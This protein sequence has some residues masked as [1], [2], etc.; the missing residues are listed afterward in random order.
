MGVKLKQMQNPGGTTGHG[1]VQQSDGSLATE[2]IIATSA[3]ST[4]S[5]IAKMGVEVGCVLKTNGDGA[6]ADSEANSVGVGVTESQSGS[7][8]TVVMG[9][10]ITLVTSG[11][12]PTPSDTILLLHM[13]GVDESTIFTDSSSSAHTTTANN[14]EIDTA[15][16]KFGGASG[17]FTGEGD[18]L[19]IPDSDDWT[20]SGD[21]TIDCWV[22]FNSTIAN[23]NEQNIISQ[24]VDDTELW[25]LWHDGTTNGW[26]FIVRDDGAGVNLDFFQG[27]NTMSIST[28][29]HV[30]VTRSGNDWKIFQD[31]V[32]V[33]SL[34]QTITFPNIATELRVGRNERNINNDYDGHID[35]L[36]ISNGTAVWTSGFT[37]PTSQY[38]T[39]GLGVWP[40][41]AGDGDPLY[42]SE[43]T[44]GLLTKTKPT[45]IGEEVL[46]VVLCTGTTTGFVLTPESISFVSQSQFLGN[47]AD[48]TRPAANSVPAGSWIYNTDDTAPNYSDATD[49]K[50]AVGVIT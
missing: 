12:T 11:D 7:N 40:E 42:L 48:G 30:A 37:P 14:I 25:G 26:R 24:R 44:P 18:F 23:N 41:S 31:G 29:T 46:R 35:E 17:L 32:V 19:S 47:F 4:K 38:S 2:E 1:V 5:I 6:L 43:S 45:G 15:Q 16:S 13:D 20:F 3:E 9:G 8:N 50:D 22:R 34:T 27:S 49:W 36:R 21:F 33:A 10:K 39:E 28:Q